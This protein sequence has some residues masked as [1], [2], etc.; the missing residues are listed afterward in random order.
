M[1]VDFGVSVLVQLPRASEFVVEARLL[2][3]PGSRSRAISLTSF[4]QPQQ[5]IP[6]KL[7]SL[8]LVQP[9][10]RSGCGMEELAPGIVNRDCCC[11]QSC[12]LAAL[13]LELLPL[14]YSIHSPHTRDTIASFTSIA[15]P[16]GSAHL[17]VDTTPSRGLWTGHHRRLTAPCTPNTLSATTHPRQTRLSRAAHCLFAF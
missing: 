11:R 7:Q 5:A 2:S 13:L 1:Q 6:S 8:S 3:G 14:Q 15:I 4:R 16:L 9:L 10:D 12:Y 17:V